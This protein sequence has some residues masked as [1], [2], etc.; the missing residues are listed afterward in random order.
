LSRWFNYL[1]NLFSRKAVIAAPPE[2]RLGIALQITG[3]FEGSGYGNVA[4]S[5][6]GQGIS[7]GILQWN[8]GQGTLQALLLKYISDHGS[9]PDHLFPEPI[10]PTAKMSAG[11]AIIFANRMQ[12][13][14][15]LKP[16]WKHAWKSFMS[17]SE[18]VAIQKEFAKL[19]GDRAESM[20]KS[21][22]MDSLRAYCW[23]FDVVVQ[24]GSMKGIPIVLGEP[25]FDLAS[26]GNKA[27]WSKMS[28]TDEQKT[29]LFASHNRAKVSVQQ[30]QADVF[31]RKATIAVGV[32][33]VHG[34]IYDL[35]LYGLS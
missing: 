29:L 15:Q 20:M 12:D 18:T 13:K 33:T 35:G 22:G 24:N 17:S 6:D 9:L 21:Y 2:D 30:F 25:I 14:R 7:A 34:K 27:V 32:G 4:G 28:F 3:A 31:N 10:T 16:E 23:F 11:A 8:Y 1:R 5:F 19:K 26:A